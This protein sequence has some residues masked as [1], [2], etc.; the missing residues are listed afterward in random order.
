MATTIA[1]KTVRFGA[2]EFQA[3]LKAASSKSDVKLER[4]H[5]Y[6]LPEGKGDAYEKINRK[7]LG[8]VTGETIA[9]DMV[10]YGVWD[11]DTFKPLSVEDL[12]A[13][14]SLGETEQIGK[15][16]HDLTVIEIAE[17]VPVKDI[18]FERSENAYF[19]AP[20]KGG[21]GARPMKL[22]YEALRAEKVAGV[23]KFVLKEG[24]RQKLAVVHAVHGKLLVNVL[25]YAGD[26]AQSE[27]SREALEALAKP[28]K[29]YLDHARMLI[30]ALT[31]DAEAS[32]L[33]TATDTAVE[34][35]AE[36]LD[37]ALAGE[38]PKQRKAKPRA[39]VTDAPD[40]L[41]ERLRSSLSEAQKAA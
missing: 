28:D 12:A 1:T 25:A 21:I 35:K 38:A 16:I 6:S 19:L 39:E 40:E 30:Q 33:A 3:A 10:T 32:M 17:F 2:V 14:K 8:A 27:E 22:L 13:I 18:E 5:K 7:D 24:G 23:T 4:A 31:V 29:V 37:K 34:A 11:D 15:E 41:L 36:A 9:T 26:F 20:Q